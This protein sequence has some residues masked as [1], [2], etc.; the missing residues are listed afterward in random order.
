MRRAFVCAG[1]LTI[2]TCLGLNWP[3]PA[4]QEKKGQP[5]T[6]Q[7]FVTM[8][9]RDGLAEVDLAN[10]ALKHAASEDVKKF[11]E[12]MLKDH[13][14]INKELNRLA[15]SKGI[16][17]AEKMDKKHR[18]LAEKL[19]ELQGADFDREYMKDMISD[20]KAAVAL[21]EREAKEG[22]DPELKDFASKTLPTLREHLKM[23][24]KIAGIEEKDEERTKD[25]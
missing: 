4:Q 14:K 7:R 21:F 25:R 13:T 8:A 15:D 17:P 5:F 23:A 1:L 16:R 3:T 2:V 6:D 24:R 22:H 12:R 18:A 11:A 9:S 10:L 20:H 19:A